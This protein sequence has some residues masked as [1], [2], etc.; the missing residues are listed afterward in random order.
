MCPSMYNCV[1]VRRLPS[2]LVNYYVIL[3]P[4]LS[5][6]LFHGGRYW[7]GGGINGTIVIGL[8]NQYMYTVL[9]TI[10]IG[11]YN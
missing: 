2:P 11:L 7:L 1:V 3:E 6:P 8:Y 9:S 10:V 5:Q 4:E